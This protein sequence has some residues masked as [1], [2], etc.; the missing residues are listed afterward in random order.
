MSNAIVCFGEMLWDILPEKELPGGALMNVAYH[1]QRL[2]ETVSLVSRVGKDARGQG[3]LDML[4]GYGLDTQYVQQDEKQETGK[5]YADMS[6]PHEVHY[7]IVYPAAWD[8]I[9]WEPPLAALLHRPDTRYLVFGSL[10]SRDVVSRHTLEQAL[11]E[12]VV[13][14][15]DINLREPHYTRGHV[16]WLLEQC[17]VLK[18]NLTEL[19]LISSWYHPYEDKEQ[20]VRLLS[21]RFS[22][23]TIVV[24]MGADGALL[25]MDNTAY[26]EP[27]IPVKVVDT[28]GSGDAFLAGFLHSVI[29]NRPARECLVFA[30][31]LGALVASFAGGCPD[32]DPGTI[33]R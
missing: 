23:H 16:E 9:Q 26:V 14:V 15:L 24:T 33:L 30:N 6:N 1:L 4:Q 11:K 8:F 21:A 19:E 20:A 31:A 2:G 5:V 12:A 22:I 13:K 29:R 18:L 3:L 28:I 25:W 17:H 27:G 10:C 7:D 32:Y